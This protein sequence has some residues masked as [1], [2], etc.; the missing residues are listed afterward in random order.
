[1]AIRERGMTLIEILVAMSL[2]AILSVLG[3]KAFSS[4]L[5]ARERL[6]S[7][8]DEWVGLA[9]VMRRVES[10]VGR[11]TRENTGK[12][13]AGPALQLQ[14]ENGKQH[15]QLAGYSSKSPEG[16]ELRHY[17]AD[18]SGL[19]WSAAL[20]GLDREILPQR[21]LDAT[22]RTRFSVMLADGNE[23][24]NWPLADGGGLDARA[25]VMTVTLAGGQRVRRVWSLP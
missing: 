3:Y 18:D 13:S 14:S 17:L 24:E 19:Q 23:S 10:D 11:L 20:A 21:L 6:V 12:D 25:L 4:L 5:I 15:L 1:M 8:S 16:R 9:R 7:L 22:S 2:M